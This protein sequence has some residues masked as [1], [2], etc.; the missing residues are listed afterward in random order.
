MSFDSLA[1]SDGIYWFKGKNGSGKSTLFKSIA[2]VIPFDGD[3][4]C[5]TFS[6][7]SQPID[8]RMLVNY[9]ETDPEFPPFLTLNDLTS[10]INKTKKG[11]SR[12]AEELITKLGMHPFK[13]Q[14]VGTFSSGML[15]KTG[16]ILSFIGNPAWIVLD[17]PFSTLDDDSTRILSDLIESLHQKGVN[18]IISS[19]IEE[20][21]HL[22]FT[23]IVQL[24]GG[25]I[26]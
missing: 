6:V 16:L 13:N 19:H 5:N 24:S 2:G 9:S 7:K 12:Y 26:E 25:S 3:I 22:P 11:S 17:E 15:K 10:Y 14:P 4:V 21:Q 8:Y 1:L 18:F 23:Q 20:D